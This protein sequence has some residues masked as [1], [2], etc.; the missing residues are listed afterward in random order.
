MSSSSDED[1]EPTSSDEDDSDMM[2]DE[3]SDEESD[4]EDDDDEDDEDDDTDDEEEEEDVEDL[5]DKATKYLTDQL[6]KKGI[7]KIEKDQH[8]ALGAYLVEDGIERNPKFEKIKVAL[9]NIFKGN[10]VNYREWIKDV[11]KEKI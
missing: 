4:D 2:D 8:I 6:N 10:T 3:E 9:L 11:Y 5:E 1:D 7:D